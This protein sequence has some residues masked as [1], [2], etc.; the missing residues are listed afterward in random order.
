ME[1]KNIRLS[2]NEDSVIILDQRLL[3]NKIEY[4]K[5]RTLE[6]MHDA[7]FTLKVRGAPAIGIFAAYAMY[8]LGGGVELGEYL[9]SAR[10]TAVNLQWAVGWNGW[11]VIAGSKGNPNPAN[12]SVDYKIEAITSLP[13]SLLIYI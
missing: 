13:T 5:L 2:E 9:K 11:S 1:L 4:L 7:I 6:E 12:E 10:P 3:P 8:V